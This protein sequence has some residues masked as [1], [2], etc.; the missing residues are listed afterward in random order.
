MISLIDKELPSSITGNDPVSGR[1]LAW[2]E[3]YRGTTIARFYQTH[4]G[5]CI[6]MLDAQAISCVSEKDAE[7]TAAF[8]KIQSEIRSVYTTVPLSLSGKVKHFTAM[9]APNVTKRE[10]LETVGLQILYTF[11]QP[12]FDDLPPFE[13][14]YM[15]TS[16]RTRHGL[17]RHG[18]ITDNG[19]IVSSAMTVAE[20]Q[21]GALLGGVAT[22]PDH[23]CLG[24]AG[25]CVLSLTSSLQVMG[26]TV[27]ICPYNPPAQ[28]LYESLGFQKHSTVTLIERM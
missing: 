23:R 14:W 28:R 17:C 15:D 25:R 11:L 6:A 22:A 26:K 8:L 2:W 19:N 13:A 5:G 7:E 10:N 3:A 12:F 4:N 16:Y 18:V 24:Y 27:W 1:L 20:W 21:S 9:V